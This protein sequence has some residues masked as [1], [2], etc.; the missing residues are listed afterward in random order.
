MF[1]QNK[2]L[3]CGPASL[4]MALKHITEKE[5]KQI[6]LHKAGTGN[7]FNTT[8]NVNEMKRAAR[9]K[10]MSLTIFNK[11]HS[12]IDVAIQIGKNKQI[13]AGIR[14]K[15]GGRTLCGN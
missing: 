5:V 9:K 8:V 7:K 2:S 6:T 15:N 13:I 3:W 1:A 12:K 4:K 11:P 10:G 14:W